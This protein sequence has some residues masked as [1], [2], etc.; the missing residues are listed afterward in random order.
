[1]KYTYIIFKFKQYKN[2]IFANFVHCGKT[3]IQ[4]YPD[5]GTDR[6]REISVFTQICLD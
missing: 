1:M 2:A 6:S 4:K 5:Y 3:R